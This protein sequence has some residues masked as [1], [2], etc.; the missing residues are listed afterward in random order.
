MRA[1]L[2]AA[3]LTS[4][5]AAAPALGQIALPQSP[6]ARPDPQDDLNRLLVQ[7]Q[8]GLAREQQQS[9]EATRRQTEADRTNALP[10]LP[11]DP[12]YRGSL[13]ER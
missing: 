6:T 7:R 9:F 5:S 2:F 10:I 3:V 4:V 12:A 1:I 8:H 13:L 11:T